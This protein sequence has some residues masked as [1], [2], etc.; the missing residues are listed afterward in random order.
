MK[1]AAIVDRRLR[2]PPPLVAVAGVVVGLLLFGGGHVTLLSGTQVGFGRRAAGGCW[3][4]GVYLGC[5]LAALGAIGLFISTLTEQPIGA[6]IALVIVSTQ[7]HPRRDPPAGLAAPVPAHP[8]LAG[9]R[10]PAARPDRLATAS[11]R[12]CCVAAAYAVVFWLAAWARFAGKDIT[13]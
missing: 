10:R 6:T 13:S 7:L 8:P 11:T 12:A 1:Y 5:G 4:S 2:R 3:L 9:L